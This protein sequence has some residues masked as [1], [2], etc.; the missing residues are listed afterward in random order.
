MYSENDLK[1]M[2]GKDYVK[3]FERGQSKFRLERLINGIDLKSNFKVADF[4]CGNGMLLPLVA[5]KVCEYT[6]IDFSEEFIQAAEK[7]KKSLS[8]QNAKFFCIDI[9]DF[10][11][12]N[13]N[14]YDV[15]FAMDFSEHVYDKDWLRILKAIRKS[16]KPGG[17][18]YIHTPNSEF[19]IERMKARDF[20]LKQFQEHIAVRSPTEN[21][22][23]LEEA[24][25]NIS[26]VEIIS[27]YNILK[28]LHPLSFI[29]LVGK[30]FKA[31]IF[32]EATTDLA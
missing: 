32:I 24:G 30:L 15:A 10:C 8:I 2:H 3:S 11:T 19:F 7:R 22:D 26:R 12:K 4:A 18:L 9:L 17:K 27:H 28:L 29:P 21:C 25:F 20:I 6:G 14:I 23:I 31:R 13:P 16:L 5:N 1:K